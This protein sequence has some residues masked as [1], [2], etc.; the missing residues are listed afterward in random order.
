[1]YNSYNESCDNATRLYDGLRCLEY[2]NWCIYKSYND[3]T[4]SCDNT[5]RQSEGQQC[6]EW[7]SLVGRSSPQRVECRSLQ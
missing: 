7:A 6:V 1:M 4:Q 3:N 5:T 2:N